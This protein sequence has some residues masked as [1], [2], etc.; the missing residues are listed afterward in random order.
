MPPAGPG[1]EGESRHRHRPRREA[2]VVNFV[3]LHEFATFCGNYPLGS[4]CNF[5]PAFED[6]VSREE[7]PALLR[8]AMKPSKIRTPDPSIFTDL[9]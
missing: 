4:L 5:V 9:H 7:A 6:N 1:C 2:E 3:D 8:M